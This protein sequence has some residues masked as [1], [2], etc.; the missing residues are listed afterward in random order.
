MEAT[1]KTNQNC[2]DLSELLRNQSR[3]KL[4]HPEDISMEGKFQEIMHMSYNLMFRVVITNGEMLL[5]LR[6]NRSKKIKYSRIW[7]G[8]L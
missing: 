5:T 7:Q 8:H 3:D 2:K 4:R 1:K 6:L